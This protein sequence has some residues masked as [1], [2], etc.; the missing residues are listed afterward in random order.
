MRTDVAA[1]AHI[2]HDRLGRTRTCVTPTLGTHMGLSP[3]GSRLGTKEDDTAFCFTAGD[4]DTAGE[5]EEEDE[6]E[7]EEDSAAGAAHPSINS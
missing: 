7:E 3:C 2:L 1:L 4:E 5:D 6:D